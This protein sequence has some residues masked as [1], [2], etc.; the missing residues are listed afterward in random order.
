MAAEGRRSLP[1][2]SAEI[3]ADAAAFEFAQ[4]LRL[5][6]DA[7]AGSGRRPLGL[8]EPPR[9]EAVELVVGHSLT[10]A[11]ASIGAVRGAAGERPILAANFLGLTGAAGVLPQH[12]TEHVAA[13]HADRDRALAAFLDLLHHRAL[14]FY[15]RAVR[16][17]R[18]QLAR[19][20]AWRWPDATDLFEGLLAALV[21]RRAAP[22]RSF[23]SMSDRAWMRC[24]G[25]FARR[26]RSAG[27]IEAIVGAF[28]GLT[29]RVRPFVGRWLEIP[30]DSRAALPSRSTPPHQ[31]QSLTG[32]RALGRRV[33]EAQS[34]VEVEIGPLNANSFLELR[35]DG[36]LFA[37]VRSIVRALLD[38][39]LEF[40]V[41]LVLEPGEVIESPLGQR[42]GPEARLGWTSFARASRVRPSARRVVYS[43]AGA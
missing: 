3:R 5:L 15:Y 24:A 10:F 35:R 14:A 37:R 38:D 26:S 32:T 40:D 31:R 30:G 16:K 13:R 8:D 39:A 34:R 17:H 36:D 27:E 43:G 4:A 12:Y 41:A 18:V 33:W 2:L 23:S 1:D 29:V 6:E 19:E 20:H 7:A 42:G 9:E 11:T 25:A 28:L 21:G 22:L